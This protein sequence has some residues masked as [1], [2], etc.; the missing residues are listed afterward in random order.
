MLK[1]DINLLYTVVNILDPVR[2]AAQVPVQ[3]HSRRAESATEDDRRRACDAQ[4]S[5]NEADAALNAAQAKLQNVDDEAA[6]RRE[7]TQSRPK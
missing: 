5:K 7:E 4:T 1:L 3:A 2:A 6:A